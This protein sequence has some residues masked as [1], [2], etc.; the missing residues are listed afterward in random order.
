MTRRSFPLTVMHHHCCQILMMMMM[1]MMLVSVLQ[2]PTYSGQ[3]PW[4]LGNLGGI[5]WNVEEL[6]IKEYE[7][8]NSRN[9]RWIPGGF[10]A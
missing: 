10:Q 8:R 2:S 6:Q 1:M 4:T 3:T 7:S 5:W 9:S